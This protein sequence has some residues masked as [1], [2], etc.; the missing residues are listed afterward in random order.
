MAEIDPTDIPLPR[1]LDPILD[2]FSSHLPG[3][4]YS[5][6]ETVL[7]HSFALFT[8]LFSL[9]YAL[10]T[11]RPS[12]WDAQTVLPP[13][14][15]L[16]A[17]YLALLSV[18]RTTSWMVRSSLWFVKWGVIAGA[19]FAGTG[20]VMGNNAAG[21]GGLTSAIG[22]IL[23]DMLNGPG[24]NAAGGARRQ[25]HRTQSRSRTPR[26][27][28][29]ESFDRH[30]EWQ[31]QE[32]RGE[33]DDGEMSKIFHDVLNAAGTAFRE[34]GWWETLKSAMDRNVENGDAEDGGDERTPRRRQPS[35]K[36]KLKTGAARSQ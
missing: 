23:L 19:L 6:L 10:A 34:G 14:I 26:P 32:D 20:W 12:E 36:T 25:T 18:Y 35:R 5:F 33:E 27:K 9:V 21:G 16:L 28:P 24:Q 17:A 2:Y 29:W 30:R 13:L 3:P 7:A 11:S 1:L 22:G 4:V 31:Y 8:A 15:S